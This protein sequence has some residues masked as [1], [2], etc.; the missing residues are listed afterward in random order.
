MTQLYLISVRMLYIHVH[1]FL[2]RLHGVTQDLELTLY[3]IRSW[4]SPTD[5][6]ATGMDH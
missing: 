1:M 5:T 6:T 3:K 4:S 2:I